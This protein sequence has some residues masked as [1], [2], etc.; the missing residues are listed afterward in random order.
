[1][2][3]AHHAQ[4]SRSLH[5]APNFHMEGRCQSVSRSAGHIRQTYIPD[6]ASTVSNW[7]HSRGLCESRTLSLCGTGTGG[8]GCAPG[9]RGAAAEGLHH[10]P[11]QGA[12]RPGSALR[13]PLAGEG[14]AHGGGRPPGAPAQL[15]SR[16][17]PRFLV[18]AVGHLWGSACSCTAPLIQP[19][20]SWLAARCLI[21]TDMSFIRASAQWGACCDQ[22]HSCSA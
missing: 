16:Q 14:P 5:E 10:G 19:A 8:A 13:R 2:R 9:G 12:L 3:Q 11:A 20:W 6:P 15:H 18:H 17:G 1:M 21:Q 7:G 4:I 22:C